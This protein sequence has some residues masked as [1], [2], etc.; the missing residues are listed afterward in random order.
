VTQLNLFKNS[1]VTLGGK[2]KFA[3]I[4]QEHHAHSCD[5][6]SAWIVIELNVKNPVPV[7]WTVEAMERWHEAK[8]LLM[9]VSEEHEHSA[10][11]F[12]SDIVIRDKRWARI[13]D[14]VKPDANSP[15]GDRRHEL[16][17]RSTRNKLLAEHA[18]A[19]GSTK[20]TLMDDLRLYWTGGQ[21]I[22]ALL[23]SFWRCG[24]LFEGMPNVLV[25]KTKG[26]RGQGL[27]LFAPTGQRSR[28]RK[29]E[30]NR[31][32][33]MA[34]TA[35]VR[36]KILAVARTFLLK[37]QS[38]SMRATSAEVL[39]E[40]FGIRDDKGKLLEGPDGEAL[41]PDEG[42]YPSDHQVRYLLRRAIPASELI[43]K[44]VSAAEHTNNYAA[45]LGTVFDD[46]TG[47]GDIYEIDATRADIWLVAK[48]DRK[49]IIGRATLYL[50]VDRD[51]GL[52]VGI[53][54]SLAPPSMEEAKQAYLSVFGDWEALCKR[55][56]VKYVAKAF[57][58]QGVG[59][60]R[61]VMDRGEGVS[62][63]SDIFCD[64]LDIEMTN[65]PAR[66]AKKKTRVEGS[67][68]LVQMP[69]QDNAA[70]YTF[71]KT[72]KLRQSK[73]YDKDASLTFDELYAIFL[74]VVIKTN[75]K[76]R[77]DSRQTPTAV[78]SKWE[79]S[80]AA[81]WTR[82]V[83]AR[84]SAPAR[85]EYEYVR[86][87]LSPMGKGTVEQRGVCFKGLEYSF[88]DAMKLDWYTRAKLRGAFEVDVAYSPSFVNSIIVH[89]PD[90][91]RKTYVAHLT[92]WYA[93]HFDAYSF[94][95]VTAYLYKQAEL[96]REGERK[97]KGQRVALADAIVTV[98]T[99]AR[100]EMKEA[101]QGVAHASRYK[102][103][104]GKRMNQSKANRAQSYDI[105]A[106]EPGA[107][108]GRGQ[109]TSPTGQEAHD[110]APKPVTATPHK[111]PAA[112]VRLVVAQVTTE[113]NLLDEL[114]ALVQP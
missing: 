109:Q 57:P 96:K 97:N 81:A 42:K 29:P 39:R 13:K 48:G 83:A 69:I 44:R 111:V 61:I 51:T 14:L 21:T 11:P 100:A 78:F 28:G 99:D 38:K 8:T 65:P 114:F 2:G 19:I 72:F 76:S 87:K 45:N 6:R 23:G 55:Y 102:D 25:V 98:S 84:G 41:L 71:P 110:G 93:K 53:H 59:C 22:D 12:P 92:S 7:R 37:D 104:L 74:N 30:N 33:P 64:G 10:M 18:A 20:E 63:K 85:Y 95:E 9:A 90:D 70:G 3:L 46:C 32:E 107:D 106:P 1:V 75:L 105:T 89:D 77:V 40:M 103:A 62:L 108:A 31:Y 52:I 49:T 26:E 56:R 34:I 66:H 73:A 47:P 24:H 17:A 4:D 68:R 58:A 5:G 94:D 67:I 16:Y 101:T 82:G 50:V 54:L 60:N 80:P 88:D 79:A 35:E 86:R 27:A 112:P 43:R 15:L 113:P 36:A 91:R